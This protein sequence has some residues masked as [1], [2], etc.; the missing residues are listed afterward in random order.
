VTVIGGQENSGGGVSVTKTVLDT[1]RRKSPLSDVVSMVV[2][3]AGHVAACLLGWADGDAD[4]FV[5]L[6]GVNFREHASSSSRVALASFVTVIGTQVNPS[7]SSSSGFLVEVIVVVVVRESVAIVTT[8]VVVKL[9]GH[10]DVDKKNDVLV[11]VS[12]FVTVPSPR[13]T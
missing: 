1:V 6:P 8:L 12:W 11:D 13:Q 7:S 2:V 5:A 3:H 9:G 10:V 4:A